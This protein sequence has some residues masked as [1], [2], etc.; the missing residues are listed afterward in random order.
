MILQSVHELLMGYG[1]KRLTEVEDENIKGFRMLS[2]VVRSC[3]SHESS[4]RNPWLS[5]ERVLFSR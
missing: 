1:V 3:F 5:H 4:E 2:T